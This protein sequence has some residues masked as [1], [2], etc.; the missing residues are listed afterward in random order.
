M[1]RLLWTQELV[2]FQGRWHTITD[3]GIHPRP[4]QQPI[5]IWFGAT[6]EPA[7][8]RAGRLGDGWLALGPPDAEQA[9][10]VEVFREAARRAGRDADALEL[11]GELRVRGE[12]QPEVWHRTVEQWRHLGANRLTVHVAPPD[13]PTIDSQLSALA[14]V[15]QALAAD[16]V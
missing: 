14:R 6:A 3:A 10:R 1:L 11:I 16:L 8:A 5:P 9:H 4:V 2:T 7:I 12:S 15:R 13:F